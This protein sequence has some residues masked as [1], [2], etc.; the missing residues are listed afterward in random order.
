[1]VC[2]MYWQIG[3]TNAVSLYFIEQPKNLQETA[4]CVRGINSLSLTPSAQYRGDG[5]LGGQGDG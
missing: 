4:E 1:M 2:E 5:A 3:G